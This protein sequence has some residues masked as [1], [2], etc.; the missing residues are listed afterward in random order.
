M[1][2][3]LSFEI[4]YENRLIF[5]AT[6]TPSSIVSIYDGVPN[7]PGHGSLLGLSE[8]YILWVALL[9]SELGSVIWQHRG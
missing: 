5:A 4:M 2:L 9:V 8:G 7:Q 6:G 1:N 3:S